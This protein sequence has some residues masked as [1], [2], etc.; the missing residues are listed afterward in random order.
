MT[1][2]AAAGK[3]RGNYRWGASVFL[4]AERSLYYVYLL[5]L[6]LYSCAA[7]SPY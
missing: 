5:T 2:S 1:F 7:F 4:A 3:W 6:R